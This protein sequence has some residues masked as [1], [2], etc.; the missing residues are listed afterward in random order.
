MRG[1]TDLRSVHGDRLRVDGSG[2]L[3]RIPKHVG[4]LRVPPSGTT[5]FQT[6]SRWLACFLKD[7]AEATELSIS[8]V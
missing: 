8:S 5:S 2:H 7:Q 6:A 3:L 1:S 4:R